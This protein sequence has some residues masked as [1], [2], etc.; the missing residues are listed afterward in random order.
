[1]A[2][3]LE[4]VNLFMPIFSFLLV[5]VIVYALL[6]KVE[7]FKEQGFL[8]FLL[9]FILAAI[10]VVN[11]SLVEFVEFSSAWFIV[12]LVCIFLIILFISFTHGS[13]E[14][15]MKPWVAWAFFGLL[16]L[17][18]I[19]S[20]AYVFNWA[21]NWAMVWNWFHTDWFGFTLLVVI[22]IIVSWVLAKKS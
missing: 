9:S 2:I 1:M 7:A 16:I 15:L 22:A 21:V 17:F 5:F 11:A 18:F 6:F 13:V 10:F 12:F 19:I 3:S 8:R 20:S 4:G 14:S